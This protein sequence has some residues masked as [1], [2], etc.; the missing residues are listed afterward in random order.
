MAGEDMHAKR[1]RS[2][3]HK[4]HFGVQTPH[5]SLCNLYILLS[6]KFLFYMP[7]I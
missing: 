5:P 1:T 7:Q 4:G 2:W 3:N 6:I